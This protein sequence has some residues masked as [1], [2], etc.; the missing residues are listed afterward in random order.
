M[1]YKSIISALEED[2]RGLARLRSEA[3]NHVARLLRRLEEAKQEEQ[4][5]KATL[6]MYRA[7]QHRAQGSGAMPLFGSEPK[8]GAA[9]RPEVKRIEPTGQTATM[10]DAELLL[11]A[12]RHVDRFA[13]IGDIEEI[14]NRLR[15]TSPLPRDH[16]RRRVGRLLQEGRLVRARYGTSKKFVYYGLPEFVQQTESGWG[17]VPG[18]EPNEYRKRSG[19]PRFEVKRPARPQEQQSE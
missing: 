4:L 14:A 18:K 1:D 6:D 7:R 15:S 5:V 10:K 11:Q 3:E 8:N 2:L 13:Q 16:I 9:S 12:V 19:K 17:F